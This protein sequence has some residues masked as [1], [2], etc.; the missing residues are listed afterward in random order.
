VLKQA[1]SCNPSPL[2]LF[3]T[4][5]IGGASLAVLANVPPS[6]TPGATTVIAALPFLLA[7]L[8]GVA[9]TTTA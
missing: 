3:S 9:K 6:H 4:G 8:L 1:Y 5:V 7:G 2:L